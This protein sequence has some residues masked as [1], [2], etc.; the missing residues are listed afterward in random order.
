MKVKSIAECSVEQSAILSTV[1]KLPV[2]IKTFVLPIFSGRFTQVLLYKSNYMIKCLHTETCA[3]A[4][5]L[6]LQNLAEKKKF[7]IKTL[8]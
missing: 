2:V 6:Y 3:C 1:I 7:Y 5:R 8:L 4:Q